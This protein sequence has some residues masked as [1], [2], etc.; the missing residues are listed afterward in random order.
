MEQKKKS[1]ETLIQQ[2]KARKEFLTLKKMQRENAENNVEHTPYADEKKPKTLG[3]KIA[4]IWYYYKT[5]IIIGLV[6]VLAGAY[7]TAQTINKKPSDL[8]IVI[9]DNKIVPDMYLHE[10]EAYFKNYCG[11]F[12]CDGEVVVTIVNCSYEAGKSTAQ[13]QQTMQQKLASIVVTDKESMIFITSDAGYEFLQNIVDTPFLK[14]EGKELSEEFYN[15][16]TEFE[17]IKMPEGLKVYCREIKGTLIE[18]DQTAMESVKRA[19]AFLDSL[20]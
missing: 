1:N 18:N 3:E 20:K 9:Y 14:E 4:H 17:G 10:A 2:E 7:I 13:Y 12:N 11:D 19:E 16:I 6:I 8:R 15:S 5:A